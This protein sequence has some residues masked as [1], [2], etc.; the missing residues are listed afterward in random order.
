MFASLNLYFSNVQL[1][2]THTFCSEQLY[3]KSYMGLKPQYDL[4]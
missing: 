3:A 4:H 1:K 2:L